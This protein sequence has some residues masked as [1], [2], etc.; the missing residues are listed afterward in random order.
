MAVLTCLGLTTS[1][2]AYGELRQVLRNEVASEID[3]GAVQVEPRNEAYLKGAREGDNDWKVR[4]CGVVRTYTCPP[5]DG[6]VQYGSTGC[7]FVEGDADAPELAEDEG[8]DLLDTPLDDAEADVEA[9]V[10]A[11][12]AGTE[13]DPAE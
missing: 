7:T 1:G 8:E 4:G 13:T 2:C 12:E 3:C 5:D 11:D 9:D 6:L 10:E